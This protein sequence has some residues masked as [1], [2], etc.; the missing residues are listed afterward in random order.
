MKNIL[1]FAFFLTAIVAHGQQRDT[2]SYS[3]DQSTTLEVMSTKVLS[4][5]QWDAPDSLKY[6]MVRTMP[7]VFG[8]RHYDCGRNDWVATQDFLACFRW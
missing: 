7:F 3:L 6:T 1:T 8:T 2:L 5:L 4:T